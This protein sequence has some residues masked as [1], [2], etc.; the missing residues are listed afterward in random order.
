MSNFHFK[1]FSKLTLKNAQESL[2]EHASRVGIYENFGQEV[3]YYLTDKY[4]V[5]PYSQ[6]DKDKKVYN[7]IK[8]LDNW[9][10]TFQG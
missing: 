8:R 5:N 7:A 1:N 2:I 3:I 4:N 6:E 10:M 9:C